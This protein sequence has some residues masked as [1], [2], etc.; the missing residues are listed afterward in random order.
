MTK[1]EKELIRKAINRLHDDDGW[2]EGISILKRLIN[3]EW[4]SPLKDLKNVGLDVIFK[5][6]DN[7]GFIFKGDLNNG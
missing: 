5:L 3:P 4:K 7:Q 6:E 2:D 1:K